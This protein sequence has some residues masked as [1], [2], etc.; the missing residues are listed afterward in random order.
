MRFPAILTAATV[1][2][3]GLSLTACSD[4]DSFTPQSDRADEAIDIIDLDLG[5]S[6]TGLSVEPIQ[7]DLSVASKADLN[8]STVS[9]RFRLPAGKSVSIAMRAEDTTLDS[10]LL[11]KNLSNDETVAAGDDQVVAAHAG[12]FDALVS[13][14]AEGD[15]DF[16]II[17]AGGA[18][19]QSGGQFRI[20]SIV[21]DNPHVDFSASGPGLK[22]VSRQLREREIALE[23]WFSIDALA[24]SNEGLLIA[25]EGA[26]AEI[27]LRRRSEFNA[28]VQRVNSDRAQLFDEMIRRSGDE[29][30]T[31]DALARALAPVYQLIRDQP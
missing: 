15:E 1:L 10:Y 9:L 18:N 26:L 23:E 12:Q 30:A 7:V 24:E 19:M 11:V 5:E 4:T 14:T 20:D 22:A 29:E 13:L 8:R 31:R 16:L 17:A 3:L 21:H 2:G 28:L 6:L 27:P 25:A